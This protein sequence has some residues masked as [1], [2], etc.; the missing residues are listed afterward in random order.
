VIFEPMSLSPRWRRLGWGL[1]T[2]AVFACASALGARIGE[3]IADSVFDD[4]DG[5]GDDAP[6]DDEDSPR[7]S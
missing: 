3:K 4:E 6:P 1:L 7:A 2:K 5:G